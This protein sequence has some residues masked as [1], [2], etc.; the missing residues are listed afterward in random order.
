MVIP[1]PLARRVNNLALR[2]NI[3]R[4]DAGDG[5]DQPCFDRVMAPFVVA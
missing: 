4:V 1:V 5:S 2:L 3:R